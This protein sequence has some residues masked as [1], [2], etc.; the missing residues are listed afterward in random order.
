MDIAS[1]DLKQDEND[2]LP[3]ARRVWAVVTISLGL[4]MAVLDSTIANVGL[5]SIAR[6][7]G[8]PPADSIWVVNAY[9]LV[10]VSLL[11]PLAALGDIFGYRRVY[12]LGIALFALASL[13]CA[14]SH[15]LPLLVTAR[16]VQGVGAAGIMSVNTALL[17]FTYPRRVLGRGLAINAMVVAVSSAIG[18]TVAATILAIGPWPWLF[19]V[20]VPIGA[21]ALAVGYFAL[22]PTARHGHRFDLASAA[23]TAAFFCLLIIGIDAVGHAEGVLHV[24]APLVVAALIGVVLVR[25]QLS[26]AAPLF[27][28]DLMLN[29]VFGLAVLTSICSFMAQGLAFVALPFLFENTL[30][31]SQVATGLL[32][33]PWPLSIAVVAPLSGRLADRFPAGLLGGVGLGITA[34]GLL[35]LALL[36]AHPALPDIVWRTCLCGVGFVLFQAPNNR[37]MLTAA[38]KSRAGAASGMLGTAR[39]LGQTIGASLVAVLFGLFGGEGTWIS[40]GTASGVAAAAAVVSATRLVGRK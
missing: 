9:Q 13:G 20:N 6:D 8:V 36:P 21:I 26:R 29:P 2:G 38:P 10:L 14:L 28:I 27:P 1:T 24:A 17:R 30:G 16:I 7:L 31:L 12:Q 4:L 18:P 22:P 39:T 40:L 23:M 3:M 37:A 19:A 11:L 15:S 35:A 32:L 34:C 33:T 25:R 5:P